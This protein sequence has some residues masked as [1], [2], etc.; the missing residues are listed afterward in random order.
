MDSIEDYGLIGNLLT[1]ALVSK[2]TGSIDHLCWP[3]FDSPMVFGRILDTEG[4]GFYQIEAIDAISTKQR[5]LPGKI[6][7]KS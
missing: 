1:A 6:D 7:F 5:Y 2:R 4:G 3:H